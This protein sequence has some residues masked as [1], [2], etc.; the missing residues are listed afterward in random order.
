M[1]LPLSDMALQN[2]AP[3]VE[4]VDPERARAYAAA[5]NDAN[6]VYA[7]GRLVPPVFAVVPTW[8]P[9]IGV[10]RHEVPPES[11]PM[12]LH[13]EQDM[14]WL[15]PLA[16]GME[17]RTEAGLYSRRVLRSGT[18]LTVR[19]SS[20][21]GAAGDPVLEQF[22]TMFVRGLVDGQDVGPDRPGHGFPAEARERLLA[23]GVVHVDDDQTFR[24]RDASGDDNPIHV[25]DEFARNVNLPG[26]ILHGLCTMAMCGS[27][28]VERAMGGDPGRLGRLAVRFSKPVFPGSDLEV[29]VFEA[30]GGAFAFEARSAGKL[31]IRDGWAEVRG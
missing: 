14:R 4:P 6:P 29:S 1:A 3:R 27:V 22:A 28:V 13:A 7:E 11:L 26:V 21:D 20:S 30:G 5:T 17:L 8:E 10:V 31:V 23:E 24:Y 25:D 12:L 19:V 18:W 9:M 2:T 16:A 15:R